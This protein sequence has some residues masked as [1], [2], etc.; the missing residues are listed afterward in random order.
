M[1]PPTS[2][3]LCSLSLFS[4][5]PPLLGVCAD[6]T[7][8]IWVT[9]PTRLSVCSSL[10]CTCAPCDGA[11]TLNDLSNHQTRNLQAIH[12]ILPSSLLNFT[13]FPFPS[14]SSL[15]LPTVFYAYLPLILP[16]SDWPGHF[17]ILEHLCWTKIQQAV[18]CHL[19]QHRKL[20]ALPPRP[21][22]QT[23]PS[24][25]FRDIRIRWV[26]FII[27]Y[28]FFYLC[29]RALS[30]SMGGFKI[31]GSNPA[32]GTFKPRSRCTTGPFVHS[33]T[34]STRSL[35]IHTN[36]N[37]YTYT[38]TPSLIFSS[39]LFTPNRSNQLSVRAHPPRRQQQ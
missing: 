27:L 10:A 26:S 23:L 20:L 39:L 35:N 4:P 22:L 34:H 2:L 38:F 31:Y 17:V 13:T 8:A 25:V 19:R 15:P 32:R 21:S 36:T 7:F 33:L 18:F 11:R 1:S 3:L 28:L 14:P 5:S 24:G 37:T 12:A 16:S 6:Q 30:S 29:K 9:L